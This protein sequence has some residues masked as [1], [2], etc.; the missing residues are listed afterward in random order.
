VTVRGP[1][2]PVTGMVVDLKALDA[3]VNARVLDEVDH[4][5]LN[6]DVPWLT[7][8]VP[9]TENLAECFFRRLEGHVPAPATL[10]EVRILE[11]ERNFVAY[12]GD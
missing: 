9:T 6:D 2:D 12:R 5:S 3:V 11:T 8:I 1:K 4:A 10:H 7:G